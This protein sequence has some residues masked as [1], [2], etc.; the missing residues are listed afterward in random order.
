MK[1]LDTKFTVGFVGAGQISRFHLQALR[2]VKHARVIGICDVNPESARQAAEAWGV[3]SWFSTLD[4]LVD[5]GANVIHVLTPPATH[6]QITLR[7]IERGCN[8]YVEKP[9]ATSAEDC[10]R[11]ASAAKGHGRSVCV[12][13]SLLYDPFVR[14]AH[15]LV[16]SGAIGT[17][18]TV[19]YFRCQ[20]PPPYHGGPTPE[21]FGDGGYPFRDLGVHALYLIESFLGPITSA[22][23]VVSSTF[24]EPHLLFDEWRVVVNCAQGTANVQL[25]WNVRPLQNLLIVQGT[26]GI[27]RVDLFG[28]SV[29]VKRRG[30]LPEHATRLANAVREGWQIGS[31][32]L[33]NTGR[34]VSGR[35]RRFHGLQTLV[36]EF[37]RT[38]AEGQPAPVG[39]EQAHSIV[40]WTER[41]ARKA[42]AR[43]KAF[44][45]E[46]DVPLRAKTLITGA[47]GLIGGRL[48]DRLLAGGERV[49]LLVRRPPT[50]LVLNHPQVE[51]VLG[52]LGDPEAVDRAVAGIETVYHLGAAMRGN[53]HDFDRGT[54]AGTRHV[55]DAALRNGVARF[56]Y[57]SS[58]SVLHALSKKA[59]RITEDWPTEPHPEQRGHYSRSKCA[60]EGYV[61]QAAKCRGLPA[62][63]L[64]PGEVVGAGAPLITSG[65]AQRRGVRMVVLG[66]GKITVPMVYVEDLVDAVLLSADKSAFAGEIYHLVDSQSPTQD[67]M[68]RQYLLESNEQL[69][70][71]HVPRVI[72]YTIGIGVQLLA[73]VFRRSP[74]LSLYRVRSAL[75][76]RRFDCARAE[77][78]LLW[79]PR[80]GVAE[81]LRRALGKSTLEAER[82]HREIGEPVASGNAAMVCQTAERS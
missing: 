64:R 17:P 82:S 4:E 37:Y 54:V 66:N 70:V 36:S 45:R 61:V 15:E 55:V 20:P 47:N 33:A 35:L 22:Y 56:V 73:S 51:V 40:D 28:M 11:I 14:R 52:D 16:R 60:A 75:A 79:R 57:M 49:R 5:A 8:V 19:D 80:V 67:G 9:L 38:L 24:R 18:L 39:P 72:V 69:R 74:P 29:S 58:L 62:V 2:R 25:S 65:I 26:E 7:A 63:I 71:V 6:A 76:S 31:Q 41:I 48:V 53:V 59:G 34:V 44:L 77:K 27:V 50:E 78:D 30:R 32:A 12:G 23:D 46:F 42:D 13:H 10:N 68:I 21:Y 43:K 1:Q 3:P 81:G